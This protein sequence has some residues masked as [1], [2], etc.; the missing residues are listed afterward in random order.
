MPS[1]ADSRSLQKRRGR[2]TGRCSA[3]SRATI[4]SSEKLPDAQ[5]FYLKNGYTP[6]LW[7]HVENSGRS[8]LEQVL[9]SELRAYPL[10]WKPA[11]WKQADRQGI[12]LALQ[13][14][15]PDE[16]LCKWIEQVVPTCQGDYLFAKGY[17]VVTDG[18][19]S[20]GE[21]SEIP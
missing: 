21:I 18:F 6:L 19:V 20:T 17:E 3:V 7:L 16:A 9:Q 10:I 11:V 13:T 2:F 12:Q 5:G 8:Q 1:M 15:A 4:F 14:P